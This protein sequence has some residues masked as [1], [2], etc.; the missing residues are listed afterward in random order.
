MEFFAG[1][2]Q[3]LSERLGGGLVVLSAYWPMQRGND[4]AHPFEQEANFWYLSGVDEARWLLVHDGQRGHTWLVRPT[5]SDVERIFNGALDEA[6]IKKRCGADEIIDEEEFEPLLRQLA[7]HHSKVYTVQPVKEAFEFVLNPA[8]KNLTRRLERIF[9]QVDDCRLELAQ[10]RAIKQPD[11]IKQLQ[12]AIDITAKAFAAAKSTLNE[13]KHEYELQAI[14]DAEFTRRGARHGY[15]PIVA[16]SKNACTL[17]Y[18][19]NSAPIRAKQLV[20]CDIGARYGGYIADITRT[21]AKGEPTARQ[22]AVL[23]AVAEAQQKIIALLR[24]GLPVVEYI[25]NSEAIM[26]Q[27]LAQLGLAREPEAVRRYMPHA[28]SHGLGIDV[29]DSLGRPK[30]FK[31]GMVLTVEPGIYI[32]RESIGVRIEDNIL[33]TDK[34]HRNLSAHISTL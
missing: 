5:L 19:Q 2:R 10:L 27:A 1:N 29:H 21:Y 8:Q 26:H 12:K 30:V 28:V 15:D 20:L 34:G 24:P 14:F 13:C 11:E 22:Q 16:A 25:E 3:Q 7:R 9:A 4:M 31:P 17:H 23:R 33:I 6:A 18:S 32:P